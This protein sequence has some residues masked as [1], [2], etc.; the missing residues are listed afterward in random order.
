MANVKNDKYNLRDRLSGTSYSGNAS[1]NAKS[2]KQKDDPYNLK[3]RL[4]LTS[5]EKQQKASAGASPRSAYMD[6]LGNGIDNEIFR[7]GASGSE[8]LAGMGRRASSLG[9]KARYALMQYSGDANNAE[10]ELDLDTAQRATKYT[11]LVRARSGDMNVLSGLDEDDPNYALYK[12]LLRLSGYDDVT[13][14]YDATELPMQRQLNDTKTYS[15][16]FNLQ[17]DYTRE[18]LMDDIGLVTTNATYGS[19]AEE[20][21]AALDR[22]NSYFGTGMTL[23]SVR[24]ENAQPMILGETKPWY[25]DELARYDADTQSMRDMIT[26]DDYDYEGYVSHMQNLAKQEQAQRDAQARY[27]EWKAGFDSKWNWLSG[28]ADYEQ[29][30]GEIVDPAMLYPAQVMPDTL[31]AGYEYMTDEEKRRFSYLYN[32]PDFGLEGDEGAEQYLKDLQEDLWRRRA[33]DLTRKTAEFTDKNALTGALGWAAARGAN[34]VNGLVGGVMSVGAPMHALF[35]D[36]ISQYDPAFNPARMGQTA[37]TTN[38]QNIAEKTQWANIGGNSRFNPF[39]ILYSGLSSAADSAA[40]GLLYGPTGGAWSQALGAGNIALM[41]GLESGKSFTDAVADAIATGAFEGLTEK[42]SMDA[43]F[44]GGTSGVKNFVRNLVTEPSEEMANML[45]NL[46]YDRLR[47][48]T[49]DDIGKRVSELITQGYTESEARMQMLKELGADA[50]ETVLTAAVAGGAGG[51]VS[52]I[53]ANA[54][55]RSFGKQIQENNTTSRLLEIAEG[56]QDM[57]EEVRALIEDQK[58]AMQATQEAQR[59]AEPQDEETVE[60]TPEASEAAQEAV[61]QPTEEA[62]EAATEEASEPAKKRPDTK[63]KTPKLDNAKLG[64]I[65]RETMQRLDE[66]ASALVE[67]SFAESTVREA[68]RRYSFLDRGTD[69]TVVQRDKPM[70]SMLERATA[71][72]IHNPT[73][74]TD[75]E[76]SVIQSSKAAMRTL[77]EFTGII[78]RDGEAELERVR[79]AADEL[80]SLAQRKTAGNAAEA[81]EK[82]APVNPEEISMTAAEAADLTV[83]EAQQVVKEYASQFGA[84]AELVQNVYEDG[85]NV[86]EFATAFRTAY[87]YG[88]E[89]W[90]IDRVVASDNLTALNDNQIRRAYELGRDARKTATAAMVQKNPAAVAVG[91]VDTAELRGIKL[92]TTQQRSIG[93][94]RR[95]AQAV[96]FNVRFVSSGVNAEG[97]FHEENG[98]WNSETRTMTI[99]VNAGR[100]DAGDA[101]YAM[102]QTVGHELTHYISDYADSDL[103]NAYQEFVFGHLSEKMDEGALNER[104]QKIIDGN[105]AKGKTLTRE[106]AAIEVVADASGDALLS[107]TEADIAELAR[108]KPTL[109]QKISDYIRKW[110]QKVVELIRKGYEGQGRNAISEQMADVADEMGRKWVALLKNANARIVESTGELL[111]TTEQGAVVSAEVAEY[112]ASDDYQPPFIFSNLFGENDPFYDDGSRADRLPFD[113]SATDDYS[114]RETDAWAEAH[115]KEYPDDENFDD[116]LAL[117]RGLNERI[118]Q[119]TVLRFL[120]PHGRTTKTSGGPLRNNIEYRRTFDMDT[121]CERTYQFLAYRDA[122]QKKIGRQLYEDEA[123]NLIELMRAYGQMIPCTYCYVEGKRMRLAE[124]YLRALKKSGSEVLGREIS[125]EQMFDEVESARAI[126]SGWLDAQLNV[127]ENYRTDETTAV[128]GFEGYRDLELPITAEQATEQV[129]EAYGVTDKAAKKV[130]AG[131]VAEWVYNR[132]MDLPMQLSAEADYRTGTIDQAVLAFHDRAIKTAQGGAKA[133]G[134]ENY[135]PYVDQLK[136]ISLED[137]RFINGMGG[138]RKHSSNDFQIQN[139]HDYMLF[140]MDLA[141]DRRGGTGWYGHTYTKNASYA[142]IFAPTNDRINVSIAMY[143]DDASGIRPN[144][145]EG[146]VWT[147]VQQLRR[148]YNNVGAMA[149]VVNNDQLSYALNSEWIDMIIPFHSSGIPKKYWNNASLKWVDFTSKQSERL[150]NGTQMKKMLK[151]RG[152][153]VP[154]SMKAAEVRQLFDETFGIKAVYDENGKRKAPHFY[155][156]DTERYGVTIPG[157]GNSAERYFELCREYGVNPRFFGIE[158]K[159]AKGEMIPITEHPGYLKL[160]KET[161]RTDTPQQEIVAKF[162][163]A[164]IEKELKGFKG[165]GNLSDDAYGIVDEFVQQYV[166]KNRPMGYLTERA[167]NTRATITEMAAEEQA[168]RDSQRERMLENIQRDGAAARSE[169]M[170]DDDVSFSVRVTD[171]KTLDFLNGQDTVKTYKTMQVVDGKLYPPMAA[172]VAGKYEDASELGQWEQATERPDLIKVDKNGKPQFVLNKGQG[173]GNVPAAYNPYMH[174]SNLVLNDQFSSA[175]DRPNLVTVECE[176]PVSEL[177]SGYHAEYA[178]DSVGWHSWHTG[179]VAGALRRSKGIERKVLLSRWI[180]PVRIVPDSEVAEMY[181]ELLDGTGIAVPDNVVPPSLLV[182]LKNIGV[183]IKVSGKVPENADT[184]Y[185]IREGVEFV[186]DKYYARMIDRFEEQNPGGYIKVGRVLEGSILYEVGLPEADL[187]FDNAKIARAL[188]EHGDHLDKG[189]LKNVPEMLRNP[190]AVTEDVRENNINV[191]SDI[192]VGRSPVLVGIVITNDRSGRN[193]IN[194]IRTVHARRNAADKINDASIL[195]L[196]SNKKR[197]RDWFQASGTHLPLGGTKFGFIR[198]IAQDDDSVNQLRDPDLISDREILANIMESA[199]ETADELDHVRRYRKRM[200]TLNQLQA[201][202]DGL[203]ESI[204]DAR[205]R[206]AKAEQAALMEKANGIARKLDREDGMLLKYES[207]KLLQAVV[208]RQREQLRRE[209]NRKASQRAQKRMKEVRQQDREHYEERIR[210][211]RAE[212]NAK[213]DELRKEKTDAVAKVRAEKNESFSKAQYR[214]EVQKHAK[215]LMDMLTTPTNKAY[216]PEFLRRPLA[217]FIAALDFS[218][219]TKLEGGADTKGDERLK[220]AMSDLATALRRVH[221]QQFGEQITGAEFFGGYLDLPG[222]FLDTFDE[223]MAKIRASLKTSPA[224]AATP[225]NKMTSEQLHDLAKVFRLLHSS[226]ANMNRLISNAKYASA[227]TAANDTMTDL[228]AIRDKR[229]HS[230]LAQKVS[231]F[232]DWKNTVPYYVF[233]RFGRGGMA[234]FEG[235]MD[236]WDK[237]AHN[238]DELVKFTDKAY[239]VSEVREWEREVQTI[240]LSSGN[241]VSM[242]TAQ[243][244]SAYCLAKRE[245]A[246]GHLLGGGIRIAD[247]G[248][249]GKVI[250]QV[251][252]HLLT[253]AD[254]KAIAKQLTP[255]QREVADALQGY[256]STKGSEWGNYVSMKRFG[257]E[258]F[259]E[260]HYFPIETD[261][262]NRAAQDEKSEGESLYRLL[263][264]SATKGLTKGANNAIVVRSIFDVFTAHMTDMAKYN[265]LGLQLLDTFKWFNYVE[266][267]QN[268]DG[269]VETRT[270]QKALEE[271]YGGDARSYIMQFLR[272]LNGVSEGGRED[273]FINKATSNYKIASTAANLRVG[274]L[275]ITSMPRAAYVINPKYLA[276]GLAKWNTSRGK[277]SAKAAEEVGI[278]KWK[279]M[280]FYD[281]N[282]NRSVRKM[283]KHD[284]NWREKAQG[285]STKLAEWGDAW[286]MGVLYGAVEAE[287]KDKHPSVQPGSKAYRELFNRRMREIVY[288][289]Q[290]VDSTMTRSQLM[291]SKGLITLATSFMSEPTLAMNMLN[292]A[293]FEARVKARAGKPWFP[294]AA[295]KVARAFGTTTFVIGL[296]SVIEALFT[297]YRDDDEFETFAEKLTKAFFGESFWD[298]ALGGN[299]N[300]LNNLPLIKDYIAAMKGNSPDNMWTAAVETLTGGVSALY[301]VLLEGGSDADIWRAVYK[302]MQGLS[303]FSGLAVSN[304]VRDLVALYNIVIPDNRAVKRLQTY[305]NTPKDAAKAIYAASMRSDT[306]MVKFYRERAALYGIDEEDISKKLQELI[307]DDIQAGKIDSATAG[308]LLKSE[309]GKRDREV[310]DIFTEAEYFEATGLELGEMKQDF[311]DGNIT[312]AQ[313]KSYLKKYQGKRDSEADK[314]LN[315][316]KYQK[317]TGLVYGEMKQDFIDGVLTESQVKSYRVT[318][319]TNQDSD[320]VAATLGEWK[321]EKDTGRLYS[322]MKLDYADGI[323]SEKQVRNY[324]AKY[325]GKNEEK[326]EETISNYDYWIATGKTNAP[327]YWRIAYAYETGGDYGAYIDEAFKTIQYGGKEKRSWKEARSQIASSLRSYYREDYLAVYGTPAGDRMLEDILDVYEAIGFTRDYERNYIADNWFD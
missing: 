252:N 148:K 6:T 28:A 194:K 220:D 103:F 62:E 52:G 312:E 168:K 133:K 238:S 71:K 153:S 245:Q 281:T 126:V 60:E 161:A 29:Y 254:L 130:I 34:L 146:A 227:V 180:K 237:L 280:G 296:S 5:E 219:V 284:E 319:G 31:T 18:K 136:S 201:E 12:R 112:M 69:G 157:H 45:L 50:L 77:G 285:W 75:Q 170:D 298:G 143:G 241:T 159:N 325:G 138:I 17:Q 49:D 277:N 167:K 182:E 266:R 79:S 175:Y 216:V 104:I 260:K 255:R 193:V 186:E 142:R 127:P 147:E 169:F 320:S 292:D 163:M 14:A 37:D 40:A 137:K 181:K 223:L 63:K 225:V 165:Y 185:S 192:W 300:L 323:I 315:E 233:K 151:E 124:L 88:Q 309:A 59:A 242:T 150:Y 109:L 90:N 155:P 275:Q 212:K 173:K 11:N 27:D 48:G 46:G 86:A 53:A 190:V 278:A 274:I 297:A 67:S 152:I 226:I 191:F 72:A 118:M 209:L 264:M 1:A 205:R 304:A 308:K 33:E 114:V 13:R 164:E 111:V 76:R 73:Q 313:A 269:T 89:G 210:Q 85:Q 134:I 57:P 200:D 265:A 240:E 198:S 188:A 119:D 206:G 306:D 162:D 229:S 202:L 235:L 166:G 268:K 158:V 234:I 311:I 140:F 39:N 54:E 55:N 91:K 183:D 156:Y 128:D 257:Y 44:K 293:I 318:Y 203:N 61:E 232:L 211:L 270:T 176:V 20:A 263:N 307:E 149:M 287:M 4:G 243:M 174:S 327:K 267:T 321:Y 207:G 144:E 43:L 58:A 236:G 195:Y 187:Y 141:A 197:T 47:Y 135:E 316:W 154:S 66:Q 56:M 244:M 172:V 271:A 30:S 125:A 290:V 10:R 299:L 121:K 102:M 273:G 248:S 117:I 19:G 247:I 310:A 218:S 42:F 131:F 239:N 230:E 246:R 122:I 32:N 22:I 92:N 279:S 214:A 7:P 288:Q 113:S 326:I 324:L 208:K 8:T 95:L 213:L 110:T 80:Y 322:E 286:T 184:T 145:Q 101:N 276:V 35:G 15:D 259:T 261:P 41:E 283:V 215:R 16:L 84:K 217:D 177:T 82:A 105:R 3:E 171:R 317:K 68:L 9:G 123:R 250:R 100:I 129:C 160:I 24:K 189:L 256:M 258:M 21:Q 204:A 74:L 94:I 253:D 231:S 199:A 36:E 291:R 224:F 289:T 65:Y 98:K 303:Q 78:A 249:R 228:E 106:Q 116:N 99:D 108:T 262:N 305:E 51:A 222:D 23:E 314:T 272:D 251:A 64:R 83:S 178:K 107:L 25:E 26:G 302:T 96:G 301:K 139:V 97:K 221:N 87:Q 38:Q 179:T 115:R 282:I 2:K 70:Q 93:A 294:A 132:R 81:E 196:D 295:P 120:V